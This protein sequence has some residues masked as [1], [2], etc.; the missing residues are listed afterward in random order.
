LRSPGSLGRFKFKSDCTFSKGHR[1]KF[2]LLSIGNQ[3]PLGIPKGS[4][5]I[6]AKEEVL[7]EALRPYL[8]I[9]WVPLAPWE[10][11]NSRAIVLSPR[12]TMQEIYDF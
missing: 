5:G 1:E 10:G 7:E 2:T 8:G 4:I 6:Q 11:L 3:E 9:L 12:A